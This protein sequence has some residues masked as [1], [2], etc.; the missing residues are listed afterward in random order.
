MPGIGQ[1]SRQLETQSIEPHMGSG[2]CA[3]A[4]LGILL[5]LFISL[6]MRVIVRCSGDGTPPRWDAY[7]LLVVQK[8][9]DDDEAPVGQWG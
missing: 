4:T 8:Q 2:S 7:N 1:S 6:P 9:V 3:S 5:L